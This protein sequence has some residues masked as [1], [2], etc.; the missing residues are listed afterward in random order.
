MCPHT[1]DLRPENIQLDL[2]L[3]GK[4][5]IRYVR[6]SGAGEPAFRV[7]FRKASTCT[8]SPVRNRAA[9]RPGPQE[10][11]AQCSWHKPCAGLHAF[12]TAAEAALG[13]LAPAGAILEAV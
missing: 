11:C 2:Q 3:F 7:P 8:L 12:K 4:S 13:V 9:G 5:I 6:S 1:S 10:A